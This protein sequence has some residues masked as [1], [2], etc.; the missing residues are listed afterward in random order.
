M[1]DELKNEFSH[2][3]L[4]EE[5]VKFW[6]DNDIF[7][8]VLKSREGCPEY[9][10]YE[11]PPTANGR[12]GVHH[13]ITR[14]Y[15]DF[16]CRYKTMRGFHV[17]R[18]AGWDTHGLP[19]EIEVEKK[20]GL[21]EKSDVEKYGIDKFN[22]ECRESVFTYKKEWDQ[23]TERIGYWLDLEHPYVTCENYYIESVWHILAKF[24]NDGLLYQGH[25]ILPY[26]P[27][28][29]TGLSSHEVA[30]GYEEVADPS[31]FIKVKVKDRDNC[32]FLVWTTTPW[33]LISN[34]GLC[35]QPRADYVRV[36]YQEQEL[37]LAEALAGK[38]LGEDFEVLEK[39]K[40]SDL[41]NW[42]YEP[43]FDYYI[44]EV[45]K[46]Y[47]VTNADFVTL[48]DGSGIVHMAP[49]FGADDYAVGQKYGLSF[50]QAVKPN[51]TFYDKVTDYAG[52]FIKDADPLI[53]RNLK[54]RGLLFKKERYLHNYPHCWRCKSPLVYYA[55]KSWYIKTTQ[56]KDK[57]IA[58]NR[59]INWCPPEIGEG[60]F[61]E[62]LENNVDWAL[63]RERYWGTPL[64]IWIG[65][66]TGKL[67]AI[68]SVDELK[69]RGEN[70]PADI[71]LH[72]PYVDNI[73]I[74]N[75]E[76]DEWMYRT[77]EVIDVWFDSGAMPFA[78]YH[79][80]FENTE[81]WDKLFPADFISEAVDQTRGWF[82]SLVAIS[83]L[84]AGVAPF[85][86]IIVCGHILDIEGKKMSKSVGNV[87]DPWEILEKYGADALRWYMVTI[88]NPWLPIRFD[89]EALAESQ[90]KMLGTLRNT[91]TFF[92]IYSNIDK[93]DDRAKEAGMGFGEFLESKAGERAEIDRWI[94]SRLNSLIK[95]VGEQLDDYNLTAAHRRIGEFVVDE[96]SN[97]YVRRCRRRF[98]GSGDDPDKF[99]AFATLYECLLQ[100]A[101]MV[102]PLMP[103]FSEKIYRELAQNGT[104]SVHL[105]S[106]PVAD[107]SLIEPEL[108]VKM[109]SAI[110]IVSLA[111]TA[112]TK[113][114]LK[115]RQP[116]ADMTVVLPKGVEQSAIEELVDV[117]SEEINI[118]N[119]SFSDN[120]AGLVTLTAKPNF[121]LLGP[122]LGKKVKSAK[123]AILELPDQVLREFKKSGALDLEIEGEKF[124]LTS[125]E[126]EIESID[127]ENYAVE[128]DNGFTVAIST[129]L[130]DELVLEGYA[131]ELVNKIQN[132]RKS[133][134][135]QVTDRIRVGIES[136]GE[137]KKALDS[138]G[139]YIK[140]ETLADDIAFNKNEG[141]VKQEW[142]LNGQPATIYVS[143]L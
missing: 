118:K 127:K 85:K 13:I 111:R 117:I 116:L 72:K 141:E 1:L 92:A 23:I 70:V 39:Y 6:N 57:L 100:V 7:H 15:K 50:V 32:Y 10:F 132:M 102:A 73:R 130:T 52:M 123:A 83:T 114:R 97:W 48:E 131:R 129:Q 133:A 91:Y 43:L 19:V 21:K 104:E 47:F 140:A 63:S 125:E 67:L 64:P 143:R 17:E 99:R 11:G 79:Y 76:D 56:F 113:S 30:Q 78:Q 74:R 40:G 71:D 37:I 18:K 115:I 80:P 27:R 46:G 110:T 69:A 59:T 62:W 120:D 86:N 58:N 87:V 14:T 119:V 112:R 88:N 107:E 29:E 33:T 24:F 51:G 25:K 34:V 65:E 49:A 35:V 22:K 106:Y 138:F 136:T 16:A 4:E 101:K 53:T 128:A 89:V 20:L 105:E 77:P 121:K 54:E 61:G 9:I 81:H 109:N 26:C 98:W 135:F 42:K 31:I 60:R 142:D 45:E 68:G 103:F 8:K 139:D 66:K 84:Y 41:E 38:I 36:S 82:Y 96:L 3:K 28:C 95:T 44:D 137:I 134:D 12:P 126:L 124:T 5:L 75:E 55:R 108:E 93:L 122:K 90:R 2:P 94:I